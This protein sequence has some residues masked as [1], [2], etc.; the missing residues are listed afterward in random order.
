MFFFVYFMLR[1]LANSAEDACQTTVHCAVSSELEGISGKFFSRCK[2]SAE[3]IHARS[4]ATGEQLWEISRV[5]C[6]VTGN[7]KTITEI[8][9]LMYE[10]EETI[11]RRSERVWKGE[12]KPT[13]L[14]EDMNVERS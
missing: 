13:K 1:P 8:P 9:H 11:A 3:S 14:P 12:Q 6:G 2:E 7:G 4:P 10:D 5:L